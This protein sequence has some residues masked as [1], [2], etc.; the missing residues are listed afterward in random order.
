MLDEKTVTVS[1][2][3]LCGI[4]LAVA[5]LMHDLDNDDLDHLYTDIDVVHAIVE[6]WAA[7]EAVLAG[8]GHPDHRCRL[9]QDRPGYAD[10]IRRRKW[11]VERVMPGMHPGDELTPG[12]STRLEMGGTSTYNRWGDEFL[13]EHISEAVVRVTHCHETGYFGL[14]ATSHTSNHP[15][16][17]TRNDY[18]V[19]PTG[20]SGRHVFPLVR[21]TEGRAGLDVRHA[22][23]RVGYSRHRAVR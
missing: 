16:T 7:D 17:R 1:Q 5:G 23:R 15:Y 8:G 20:I 6:E 19:D 12:L 3:D 9:C 4:S 18:E 14:S 2:K 13:L 22:A 10:W 11:A 21:D